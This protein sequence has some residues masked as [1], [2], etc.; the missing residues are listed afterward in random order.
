MKIVI[1][2]TGA[3]GAGKDTIA[4]IIREV[5]PEYKVKAVAFADPIK[6]EIIH[7]FKLS[8]TNEYD[9]FKRDNIIW[10]TGSI[11]GRHVVREIGMMMRRYDSNQF[12][13][14]VTDTI[15]KETDVDIF[16][17]TDLRFDN[18]YMCLKDIG[19]TIVK[20]RNYRAE[21]HDAH[22]TERGFDDD[23]VDYVIQNNETMEVLKN[24]VRKFIDGQIR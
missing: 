24:E 11:D 21:H 18:E 8:G 16:V 1:G 19:A 15:A 6:R 9:R 4:D 5:C 14:Y 10:S 12:T 2:L 13:K 17:I 20:V 7:T 22:I 3:K 23:L